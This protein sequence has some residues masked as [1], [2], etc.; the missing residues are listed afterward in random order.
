MKGRVFRVLLGCSLFLVVGGEAQN[1][2]AADK[3]VWTLEFI[4]V[5][6]GVTPGFAGAMAY[7]DD[8]WMRVRAEAK[9]EGAVLD[10]QP[11][12][13]CG[14]TD[15]SIQIWRS[16]LPGVDDGIQEPGGHRG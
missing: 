2:D 15:T 13:K 1:K 5:M 6:P 9:K 14:D 16:E 8:N 12:T 4:R 7:L 11:H 10:Y 3:P